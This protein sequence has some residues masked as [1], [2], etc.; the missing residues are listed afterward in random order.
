MKTRQYLMK[1][2]GFLFL[3]CAISLNVSAQFG[4]GTFPA[5]STAVDTPRLNIF[6]QNPANMGGNVPVTTPTNTLPNFQQRID[7]LKKQGVSQQDIETYINDL[8]NGKNPSAPKASITPTNVTPPSPT[9]PTVVEN[10]EEKEPAKPEL[11]TET[12][13]TFKQFLEQNGGISKKGNQIEIEKTIKDKLDISRVD[14]I[15][16]MVWNNDSMRY[17]S[18]WYMPP[19]V[20]RERPINNYVFGHDFFLNKNLKAIADTFSIAPPDDYIIQAG[21]EFGVSAWNGTSMTSDN[22]LV[23]SD[24]SVSRQYVG[25]KFVAGM[26][27]KDARNLLENAYKNILP[28][29]AMLRIRLSKSVS[30]ISVN[31][32]G[33]VKNPGTFIMSNYATL[34]NA[35]MMAGGITDLAT[36]RNIY[37]KRDGKQEEVLDLYSLIIDGK[38]KPIYLKNNDYIFVPMQGDIVN[39]SGFVKRPRRYEMKEGEDIGTLL[40]YAGGVRNTARTNNVKVKR[41]YDGQLEVI[42]VNLKTSKSQRLQ[43]GDVVEVEEAIAELI[44]IVEVR[45]Y[46]AYPNNYQFRQGMKV[47]DLIELGGGLKKNA[48]LEKAYV[49]R[50]VKY[51]EVSYIPINLKNIQNYSDPNN[52]TL[53]PLD[54]LIVFNGDLGEI[55]KTIEIRGEVY[56]KG[57][58][59][60]AP[61]MTLKDVLYLANGLKPHADYDH[62]EL[63]Y[64][65]NKGREE[66]PNYGTKEGVQE[67]DYTDTKTRRIAIKEDWKNDP[68]LDTIFVE[69]YRYVQV[70]SRFEDY[71][72]L[73]FRVEG[74]V[75]KPTIIPLTPTLTLKD[76]LFL[77]GGFSQDA[78]YNHIELGYYTYSGNA[79]KDLNYKLEQE[80][81]DIPMTEITDV[82][83]FAIN[84][85][86]K[87]DPTLDTIVLAKYRYLK[88]YSR[89]DDYI[90]KTFT[91]R[92]AVKKSVKIPLTAGL[93]LKDVLYLAGGPAENADYNQVELG[94][95]TYS[96]NEK[97]PNLNIS[98]ET[99]SLRPYTEIGVRRFKLSVDWKNDA[100]LD[101]IMLSKYRYFHVY[102]LETYEG[103][104]I[105]VSGAVKNPRSI[106]LNATLTLRDALFLC[107]GIEKDADLEHI[108]LSFFQNI[109]ATNADSLNLDAAAENSVLRHIAI[110]SNWRTDTTLDTVLLKNYRYMK[111]YS[112]NQYRWKREVAV[113]G[114]VESPKTLV[115]VK[116]MTLKDVLYLCG[117][118]RRDEEDYYIVDLYEHFRQQDV[119]SLNLKPYNRNITRMVIEKNW[120]KDKKIDSMIITN[121]D[122]IIFHS[123]N[124][125]YYEGFAEIK[126][127][128]KSPGKFKV[129][130]K[131]SL[132]DVLYRAGGVPMETDFANIEISRVL[133]I[134]NTN[135]DIIVKPVKIKKYSI[136]Q[137]WRNDKKIDSVFIYAFDQ[138]FVR[139]NY[140]FKLQK[141]VFVEGEVRTPGEYS[142]ISPTERLSSLIKRANG[143]TPESFAAGA[144]LSRVNLNAT[145]TL[146]IQLDKAIRHPRSKY[147]LILREGDIL[148]IPV[149]DPTVRIKGNVLVPNSYVSYDKRHKGFLYYV[150]LGGGFAKRTQRNECRV[151]YANGMSKGTKRILFF[152]NVYPEILPGSTLIIPQ[153]P[154]KGEGLF[155]QRQQVGAT[156]KELTADV[157]S[158]LSLVALMRA[159]TK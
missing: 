50:M 133:K 93:S 121:Y 103:K 15:L 99:G 82:R 102:P 22:L 147:D 152:I 18:V 55:N 110:T 87:D 158:V 154:E 130:P 36:V 52:I 45:G 124:E 41:L 101:T 54:Q 85:S 150:N 60:I 115:Q 72:N 64:F 151:L 28:N 119:G 7:E 104:T 86:W 144:K 126:G 76:V 4:F 100:S 63:G 88:V 40:R 16:K 25:R 134:E 111:V 143:L 11:P 105:S 56:S 67:E 153:K 71:K 43:D 138:V 27:Y 96:G 128:V 95:Y 51:N 2:L 116:G 33:E 23:E 108:E 120:W 47:K 97:D 123:Q 39:I 77:V 5:T 137:D 135:G 26:T 94:Y 140:D 68:T 83:R 127:L 106:Q 91:V 1:S 129:Q 57:T 17:D 81:G 48:E 148:T 146:V 46:V 90:G 155:A 156:I 157:A 13:M 80:K 66:D 42:D 6:N 69:K 59:K 107:G 53:Q 20:K 113:R 14:S 109:E 74:S 3:F 58:F 37:V 35:L 139:P 136:S 62:I 32:V 142:K 49:V 44:N 9:T 34:L 12:M 21:D 30:K 149:I 125:F 79:N 10:V 159:I 92:G 70:Y 78:D 114:V 131:M 122:E 98:F 61:K 8:Q 31:I 73:K 84:P 75:K 19:P 89:Y 145:D 118:L 141:N 24:G 117:G 38:M 29:G 112:K 65:K 132:K